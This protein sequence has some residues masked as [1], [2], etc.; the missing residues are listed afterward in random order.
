MVRTS[1]SQRPKPK[2]KPSR[3]MLKGRSIRNQFFWLNFSKYSSSCLCSH[4][5]RLMLQMD[6]MWNF[7]HNCSSDIC[8]KSN[9]QELSNPI[10]MAVYPKFFCLWWNSSSPALKCLR[11]AWYNIL[12]MYFYFSSRLHLTVSESMHNSLERYGSKKQM[13]QFR[14]PKYYNIW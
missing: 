7:Y 13:Y 12:G 1:K 8:T 3:L 9:F 4:E 14:S 6:Y 10:Y 11:S 2:S 5:H